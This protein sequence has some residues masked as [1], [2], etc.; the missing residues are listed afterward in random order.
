MA[1]CA[2]TDGLFFAAGLWYDP[3]RMGR[4]IAVA[5][6]KGGVGKTTTAVNVAASLAIA[7][8]APVLLVDLDPQGNASAGVGLDR[9]RLGATLYDVMID[10]KPAAAAVVSTAV[11]CLDLIPASVDLAGVEVELLDHP[12]RETVLKSALSGLVEKYRFIILDCPPS[13][14]VLTVN[15]L[16]A[17]HS[18]LV[19]VQCEYYALEGLRQL[20][21]TIRLVRAGPN[22]NLA[23]E[24]LALTMFD[25]RTTLCHDV[26]REVRERFAWQVFASVIPRN[27]ALAEAPSHGKPVALYDAGSRGAQAYLALAKEVVAHDEA[28]SG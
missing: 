20:L 8:R 27:V 23:I 5:N 25:S 11:P 2:L 24:G 22:P 17:A 9:R 7:E 6:Q 28:S 15:G 14:G 3:R 12:A 13:L 1:V 10:R 26:A 4:V 21:E 19:P 18:V 16:V